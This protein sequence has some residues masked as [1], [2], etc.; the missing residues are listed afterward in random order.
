MQLKLAALILSEALLACGARAPAQPPKPAE[1]KR[2]AQLLHTDLEQLAEIAHRLRG[3]CPEL[4]VELQAHVTRMRAHAAEVKQAEQDP[5]LAAELHTEL[6]TYDDRARGMNDT[7]ASD[8]AAS[9]LSCK[10][11]LEL[12][13]AIDQ[14]P[15]L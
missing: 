5:K 3:R 10:T 13:A 4:V 6:T 1:S 14:I 2:L 9:Y 12:R 11:N 8:L 15:S 7:I